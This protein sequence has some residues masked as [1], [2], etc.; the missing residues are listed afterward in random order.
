MTPE[1]MEEIKRHFGVVTEQLRHEIQQVAEGHTTILH[2]IQGFRKEMLGEFKEVRA[3]T[4][5]R[6]PN[7]IKG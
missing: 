5:S 2:H 3:L 4:S 6:M 7:W 1:E